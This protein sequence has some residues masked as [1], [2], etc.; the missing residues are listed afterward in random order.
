MEAKLLV[1]GVGLIGYKHCE[2]IL[3][4]SRSNLCGIVRGSKK[5]FSTNGKVYPSYQ[6][7]EHAILQEKPDG[8]I[9]ASPNQVHL[10]HALICI[11]HGIPVLIE[12]PIADKL[13]DAFAI[14]KAADAKNVPVLIGHHRIHSEG[15]A[16]LKNILESGTLGEIQTFAGMATFFKPDAYFEDGPWRLKEGGGPIAI[17]MIHEICNMRYLIGEIAEIKLITSNSRRKAVVEDK[18]SF[19]L[20]FKSGAIGTFILSDCSSSPNSWEN[21]TGENKAYPQYNEAC[22]FITGTQGSV[23]FPD[24]KLYTSEKNASW[25]NR[26]DAKLIEYGVNDPLQ[27]QLEHFV[28]IIAQGHSPKVTAHDGYKN[29]ELLLNAC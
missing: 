21:T 5:P 27:A 13:N 11:D 24:G 4:S 19:A 9:I 28:N 1:V 7:L 14:V 22:Y 6:N 2:L 12:K 16:Q 10:E 29:L 8:V 17:N 20:R 3:G 23:S 26:L 25:M 15:M 18:A